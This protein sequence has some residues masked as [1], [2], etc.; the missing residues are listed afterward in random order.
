M[1]DPAAALATQLKHI[2]NRTGQSLDRLY[3]Q[4]AGAGLSKHAELRSWA[5]QTWG[6]GYGD[7]NTLVHCAKQ[8]AAPAPAAE[9][10]PMDTWYAGPKAALRPIHDAV[11][12][13]VRVLGPFESAPKKSY[14]SLRRKKQFAMLGPATRSQ[15]ELGLNARELPGH[16]R[17]KRLPDGG[18][19]RYAIRL[20]SPAEVD[21]TLRGWLRAAYD[22]A[23]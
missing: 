2:E 3:A 23:G 16:G 15:V 8:A 10:D 22:E 14:V 12:D 20:S 19:C 4:L 21:D 17:L 5:Q 11:M 9:E 7:A 6:L 13:A 1:A 18:M